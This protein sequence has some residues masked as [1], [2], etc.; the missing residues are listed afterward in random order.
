[1]LTPEEIQLVKDNRENIRFF[2]DDVWQTPVGY[3]GQ[4]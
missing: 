2:I 1:M 3:K 4:L